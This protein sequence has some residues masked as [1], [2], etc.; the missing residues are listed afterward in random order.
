MRTV[1]QRVKSASVTVDGQLISSIGKGLLVLAAISKDDTEKDVTSMA[2]KILKA[3]LWDD[4]TK[5]PPG[6]WKCGVQDVEGEILCVSQF[7]LLASMKKGNRPDFHLSASGVKAKTLYQA[8]FKEVGELY[9][10]DKVKDGLFAANMD[11]ALINDGPVTIQLD[12]NPPK[13]EDP[14]SLGPGFTSPNGSSS[15]TID[16][17]DLVNNMT[18][19]TKEFQ[20]PAELLE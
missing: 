11:V 15:Q 13:M 7:T 12:T 18:R 10:T 17:N 16:V 20:I 14:T 1:L 3:K 19:I 8:F 5:E 2:S 6:R 4:D 9:E